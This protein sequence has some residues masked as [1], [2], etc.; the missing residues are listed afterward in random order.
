MLTVLNLHMQ[1][2]VSIYD[3]LRDDFNTMGKK[4]QGEESIVRKVCLFVYL[5]I[6]VT[7]YVK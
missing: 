5:F 7:W 6:I 1:R 3:A 4:N 2:L